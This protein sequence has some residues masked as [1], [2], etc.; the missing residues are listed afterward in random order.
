MVLGHS[1]GNPCPQV[2]MSAQAGLWFQPVPS[3]AY[4]LIQWHDLAMGLGPF[5]VLD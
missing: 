4:L 2:H 3:Y 5:I 1:H